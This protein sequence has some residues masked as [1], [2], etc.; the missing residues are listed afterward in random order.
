MIRR[1]GL[2][3]KWMMAGMLLAMGSAAQ[4]GPI[5]FTLD[6]SV[7]LGYDANPFLSAGSDTS[8]GYV[9]ASIEP[10]LTQRNATGEVSLSGHFDRTE[11]LRNYGHNNNYGAEFEAKQRVSAKL[12]LFAGL[13]YDSEVIGQGDDAVTGGVP[14]IDVNLIGLRR[15]AETFA[16]SGGFQYQPTS[17]DTISVSGGTTAIRYG[18]GPDGND[19]TNIGGSVGWQHAI[20]GKTKFGVRSSLYRIDYDTP[21]LSTLIMQPE[22]TF[23]TALTATWTIEAG[24]GVSFSRLTLP[25]GGNDINTNGLSG[26]LQACHKGVK[27]NLCIYGERTVSASGAGGTA[28]RTQG[29]INYRHAINPRLNFLANATYARS[30]SQAGFLDTRD[31]VSGSAGLEWQASKRLR[32]GAQGRYRDVYG[33]GEIYATMALVR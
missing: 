29:G 17:K 21:G 19:S 6:G 8:T 25:G 7:R 12:N 1:G 18:N 13:R 31:Y 10:K 24:L 9:Q 14:D 32:L 16:A 15:R 23:T 30:K 33:Q 26:S 28:V 27:D 22:V 3:R 20:N 5:D 4:A 2:L 11:Y